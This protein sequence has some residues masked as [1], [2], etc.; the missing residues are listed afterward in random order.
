VDGK[1]VLRFNHY[2]KEVAV[3]TSEAAPAAAVAH[4]AVDELFCFNAVYSG[5]FRI[6]LR[7]PGRK[8][9]R[10]PFDPATQA[11]G[12]LLP[13]EEYWAEVDAD[14]A[15]DEAARGGQSVRV[16]KHEGDT[17]AAGGAPAR[18]AQTKELFSMSAAEIREA[19]P[20]YQQLL[21]ERE[22]ASMGY[23]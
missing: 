11:I 7:G 23:S 10:M 12:G 4:A 8:G 15:A 14:E 19:G 1:L 6:H 17:P 2:R 13:G 16:F 18:D 20:K 5:Q 9:P 3:V 21:E 22:L